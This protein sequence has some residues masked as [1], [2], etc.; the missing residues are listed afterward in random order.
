MGK[1]FLNGLEEIANRNSNLI[2]E[3]RGRG[4]MTGMEFF[5]ESDALLAMISIVKEGVLNNSCHNKEDTLIIMPPL[6]VQEEDIEEIIIRINQGI[7]NFKKIRS[8]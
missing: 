7:R 1:I 5:K 6:I 3:V 8:K 4:L 2:K